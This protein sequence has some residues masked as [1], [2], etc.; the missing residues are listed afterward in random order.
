VQDGKPGTSR[1]RI[2]KVLDGC[3]VL[4]EFDG[5]PG[6]PLVG[7][8]YSA[9]DRTTKQWRQTWVDNTGSYLDFAGGMVDG[10]MV[11]AREFRRG[12]KLLKQRMVFEDIRADSLKW[13]W[14]GSQDGGATWT[15]AWEIAYRRVK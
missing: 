14:Q 4:E 11:L 10:R 7:R 6:T 2:T 12:E 5:P 15:T 13:L 9:Y 1:N 8:S 3:A